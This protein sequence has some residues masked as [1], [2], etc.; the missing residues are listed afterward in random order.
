MY[1]TSALTHALI[2][3]TAAISSRQR[4]A[5]LRSNGSTS[6]ARLGPAQWGTL[7]YSASTI[8]AFIPLSSILRR[9]S[10]VL[11]AVPYTHCACT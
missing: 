9:N 6:G 8:Y 7:T 5:S 4:Y 3:A 11:A 2:H 10:N 1:C